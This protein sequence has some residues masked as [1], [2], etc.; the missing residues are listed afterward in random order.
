[1]KY[2]LKRILSA[3]LSALLLAPM[4]MMPMETAAA[5]ASE[6]T[7]SDLKVCSFEEPLGV[8]IT[9]AFS[10]TVTGTGWGEK[11]TAYRIV[12]STTEQKAAAGT[13]DVWDSGKVA[14]DETVDI[15]YGGKALASR[16]AYYW[17][18]TVWDAAGRTADS[19]PAR[20]STG[21]LQENEWK[22]D[23][24]GFPR[25]KTDLDLTGCKW[26][27][28]AGTTTPGGVPAGT[29]YF[30][31]SFTL[32]EGK[33]VK[34]AAVG[35]TADDNATLY[36][37]GKE[38]SSTKSW[39]TGGLYNATDAL[40][41]NNTVAIR[42]TN[43]TDGWG[44]MIAKLEVHYTDG[45]KDTIVTDSGW[46][47]SKT[48]EAGWTGVG[49]DDTSW[50]NADQQIPFGDEPWKTGISLEEDE[51][52]AAVMLRKEFD[53]EKP[54]SEAFAYVCG[55]GFFEM[56]VN[57]QRTDDSVLN[58]FNT[59]YD[60]ASLYCAYDVTSL[61]KQ[62]GNALGV[63]LG[64]SYYNEIGGV[65][66]WSTASWRDNPKLLMQLE[67]RYA[68][69]TSETIVSDESWKMTRE[70]PITANSM[71]YGDVYDARLEMPGWT[72]PGFDESAWKGAQLME[73]PGGK[74]RNQMKAPA[75]RVAA[76]EP[77][78][79]VKLGEGSYR[80]ESPEMVSGWIKLKNINQKAGDTIKITYGQRLD[81]DGSVME[82]GGGDGEIGNWWPHAYLQQDIYTSAG[83]KNESYEP[84]F[85]FKGFEYAQVD[86]FSGDLTAADVEIYR[87]SNSVDIV[88]EFESSN[89]LFNRLH[90]M[91][92]N[93]MADNF[94]GEHCDPMLEKNGWLGDANVSLTSLM[95]NFDMTGSL[96]AF[97]NLME[98]SFYRYET[99]PVMVPTADWWCD[100]SVVWNSIFVYGVRDLADYYGTDSF[101]EEQ[102]EAM[103]K[104]AL[105][106]IEEIESNGWV[107]FDNQLADWVA[108]VGGSDPNVNYNE[109]VS[110]GSGI[111]G[112]AFVYGVLDTM[113]QFA[114]DMGKRD[115]AR[116]YKQAMQKI[117]DAFNK[118]F[119]DADRGCYETT[120]WTQIG[121]RTKYRQTSNLV[122]LAFGL[123]PDEYVESVVDSLV[124]DIKEKDYHLDTGCVGTKY[125][126]PILCDYGHEDIAYRI[127]TQDT[128]PSWGFMVANDAKGTW[129]MWES[130]TRSFDHYFLGTYD[131]WFYSHLA[132]VKDMENG[133]KNFTVEPSMIGDLTSAK[134]TI[135]TV[136]GQVVSDWS[137]L[138]NGK[139]RLTVRVP[140]GS[141]AKVV[142]PTASKDGVKLNDQTLSASVAGVDKI[143]V[144]SGKLSVTVGSGEYVF[145]TPTDLTSLYTLSLE[146]TIEK[147]EG[148]AGESIPALAAALAEAKRV[149]GDQKATQLQINEA[150]D[151]LAD[152]LTFIEGSDT[153]K[154]LRRQIDETKALR[155]QAFYMPAA[156]LSYQSALTAA[157]TLAA[158]PMAADAQL[159]A[160]AA[161][162]AEA[163]KALDSAA[164]E[165]LAKG[166]TAIASS[167]NEDDY[168]GW[169]IRYV[170]DGNR[171]NEGRQAGEYVGYCSNLTPDKDH[172]EWIYVDLGKEQPVNNM[173]I[174]A[175]STLIDGKWLSYGF[176]KDFTID[177][178]TDGKNWTT[179][180]TETDFPLSAYGAL[181]F[182]FDRTE[183]RFVRLNAQRL[184]P[185]VTDG[186]GYRLQLSEIEVYNLPAETTQKGMLYLRAEG[187]LLD[188]VFHTDTTAYTLKV[189]AY[190]S[191]VTF[192]PV[193][194][195]GAAVTIDGKTVASGAASA[196]IE[197]KES[198]QTITVKAAGKTYTLRVERTPSTADDGKKALEMTLGEAA[199]AKAGA[200]Y[201][202]AVES[203]RRNFDLCY[204]RAQRVYADLTATEDEI[205]S[206]WTGLMDA[207]HKLGVQAGDKKLLNAEI[208]KAE[209]I[210]LAGYAETGKT[211]FRA[212]LAE[213]R[214]VQGDGDAQ[215]SEID[216]ALKDLQ[217]TAKALKP[218]AIVKG[219]LTKDG[220]VN[221]SDI[222]A[223]CKI[224]ARKSAGQDPTEDEIAR[225]DVNG[226]TKITITDV[227]GICKIIAKKA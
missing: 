148:Y 85:S 159:T 144:V 95:Y 46:K 137:L 9:P 73:A 112:T 4:A 214:R 226:D 19:A 141:T 170:T 138:E 200:D 72:E 43:A 16:T 111:V 185:K 61:L 191:S 64:N 30:R 65:W 108:P 110:E 93:S 143:A 94:Q 101:T 54:V 219:D 45:T 134:A 205:T 82:Y 100:N 56:S 199:A 26:I 213:A 201:A 168:W 96:P 34:S 77:E 22:G 163:D 3:F 151:A 193:T 17:R 84:K 6:I 165:N 120:V 188:P 79:I 42:A 23:W 139:A 192:T 41:K 129:E 104:F 207:I 224:L 153:R 52:R 216:K 107:W 91:M 24:I 48:E 109:N 218:L 154:A 223:A 172:A 18:V 98:D 169:G 28:L 35:Y 119:Y 204:L 222:M 227:M 103:R 33:T 136:R 68:D 39:S 51:T 105:K 211:A 179:V 147:A 176:P 88:S 149:L 11:Q 29:Q 123:V 20:F 25:L 70:G 5:P 60:Q 177:V 32:P 209:K 194:S 126:L 125:I 89:P 180:H 15:A 187:G 195:D 40:Q 182:G 87:V 71:Y 75:K 183:A 189:G 36:L 81:T 50:K 114:D 157:E 181:S 162:L 196:P 116:E 59:Q 106:D 158:D 99:L 38:I 202:G 155:R 156:W 80:I 128:Y 14:S 115:D 118:K 92:R 1:M 47:V 146:S 44:G 197:I 210:D 220:K 206:A 212:A 57:G 2:S 97:I 74:L 184:R 102:Y 8:D 7:V 21:V 27:W 215:Q 122:P 217:D 62:G 171:K 10:W 186:N 86:G 58:P 130:T 63:E 117:Y 90:K 124:K 166:K 225:G 150:R 152:I 140:F 12:L 53:L 76:L 131:E 31:K 208:E 132:G 78:S 164:Y 175:G 178:S 167:S 135:D 133:Y 190:S 145:E 66:N 173:T 69:G 121:S 221:V 160:A 203:A 127:A 198:G 67:I 113:V 174:Y 37:N 49:Y 13:G 161:K 142:L 83:G 55:L